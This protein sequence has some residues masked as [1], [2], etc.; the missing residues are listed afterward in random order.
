[1]SLLVKRSLAR[2]DRLLVNLLNDRQK[3]TSQHY[4]YNIK[5][6]D[7]AIIISKYIDTG[8]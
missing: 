4:N 6:V 1:M 8:E 5:N 2:S 3:T 7:A